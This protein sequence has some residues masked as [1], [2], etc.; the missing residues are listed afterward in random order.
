V[1]L[2]G[3]GGPDM[4]RYAAIVEAI[5]KLPQ[6]QREAVLLTH[7]RRWNTRLCAV[8]MDCSNTAVETHLQEGERQL[9]PL[10]GNAYGPLMD[11]LHRVFQ[12]LVLTLP[13]APA[14][15]A[16][17]VRR[18]QV[19]GWAKQLVGWLIIALIVVAV[20]LF[21]VLVLPRIEI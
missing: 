10:A 1:L 17:R 16:R 12:S 6:Q 3:V 2:E 19:G 8:A 15:F 9:R 13:Y 14:D 7:A 21:L 20:V 4:V 5:R 11:Y 18:E